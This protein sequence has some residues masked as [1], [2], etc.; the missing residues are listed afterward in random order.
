MAVEFFEWDLSEKVDGKRIIPC[1]YHDSFDREIL[2]ATIG[3]PE[4]PQDL[5]I[6]SARRLVVAKVISEVEYNQVMNRINMP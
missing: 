4:A 2:K 5:R 3:N 1:Y 6:R